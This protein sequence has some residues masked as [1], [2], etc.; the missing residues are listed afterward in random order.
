MPPEPATEPKAAA[1]RGLGG[2]LPPV[3]G[4]AGFVGGVLWAMKAAVYGNVAPAQPAGAADTL[5]FV[6]PLLLIL[7][8]VGLYVR[9]AE[10]MGGAAKGGFVQALIGL[11]LL[12]A[13]FLA[14]LTFGVTGAE[15]AYLFGFLILAFGLVLVGLA[16]VKTN[17]LGRFSP[18]PL[19]LGLLIPLSVVAGAEP[20]R[21][22]LSALFGLGWATLGLMLLLGLRGAGDGGAV[23]PATER[24]RRRR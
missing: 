18:L 15:R 6:V 5:F 2:V 13:G 1:P 4:T 9:H 19:A 20:L 22:V 12:A 24:G 16:A 10:G 21:A 7:G 11:V 14:D 23:A 3:G 8:L 17:S